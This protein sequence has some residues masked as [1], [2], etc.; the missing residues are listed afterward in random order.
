MRECDKT[1]QKTSDSLHKKNIITAK[2]KE[3][4][5]VQKEIASINIKRESFLAEAKRKNAET[6][7]VATLETAMEKII[8][9]QAKR[10]NM[11]IQ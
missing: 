10:F 8:K 1:A 3:R 7:K 9:D 11:S 5:T 2:S 6:H 4:M